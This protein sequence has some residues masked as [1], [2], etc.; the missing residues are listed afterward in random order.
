M[1]PVTMS[2]LIMGGLNLLNNL[3]SSGAASGAADTLAGGNQAA[4][5][6]IM[7]MYQTDLQQQQPFLQGSQTAYGAQQAGLYGGLYDTPIQ[8]FNMANYG[9]WSPDKLKD[10]PGYNF[11]LNEGLNAIEGRGAARGNRL[12]GSTLKD[13][14][15]YGQG[16]ASNEADKAYQRY[17]KDRGFQYG[18][19]QDY[20]RNMQN[21]L[22]SRW[23]RLDQ[24]AGT[25]GSGLGS[26]YQNQIS[27]LMQNI[28]GYTAAGDTQDQTGTLNSIIEA[29]KSIIPLLGGE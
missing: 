24:L 22:G 9:T 14:T 23:N 7:K 27:N 17:I 19:E 5:D 2:M 20:T 12:S 25:P 21:E 28:A 3:N 1:D 11:R 13:L 29:V 10:D 8:E 6:A 4:L 18:G 26:A 16:F 15:E